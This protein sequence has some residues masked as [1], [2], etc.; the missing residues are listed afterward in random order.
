MSQAG[1]D[2]I[3]VMLCD[4]RGC[5]TWRSMID[6]PLQVGQVVWQHLSPPSQE[7][8]KAAV[9][10]VA[11]LRESQ[12]LELENQRGERFR[13]WLWPLAS[14]DVA[15]CI[16]GTR[17]PSELARLTEREHACL[18]LL[19]QG[20]ETRVIAQQLD[21]SVSTVH[22][23]LKRAREKLGLPNVETLIS[24]A[25]RHCFPRTQ[26]LVDSKAGD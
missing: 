17:I 21:C 16:L 23:H 9:S 19:S 18:A 11:T 12:H 25:A 3:F 14:P 1:V 20:I 13:V 26:A 10:R 15:V 4:W 6:H 24:F 7:L 22:T 5:C 8:A 2:D